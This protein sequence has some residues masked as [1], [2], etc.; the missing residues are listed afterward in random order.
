MKGPG[1][2]NADTDKGF[3]QKPES[4]TLPFLKMTEKFSRRVDVPAGEDVFKRTYFVA[5]DQ[6]RLNFHFGEDRITASSRLYTK[7]GLTHITEVDTLK[8]K[9]TGSALLEEYQRLLLAERECSQ[10]IRDVEREIRSILD[11]RMKEEQNIIL[12][13]PYYDV[14]R[15]KKEESDEEK[16]EEEQV[17]HDFLSA[18]LPSTINIRH[19]TRTECFAV[20]DKCLK[21]LKDRLIERANIIQARHDEETAALA[22]RQANFQRDRDQ[23]S[24]EEEEEYEKACEESMFRI[25]ILEQRL[26]KHEEQALQKYYQLDSKLRNDPRLAAMSMSTGD[27]KKGL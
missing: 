14:T 8:E 11:S 26:K 20:R 4:Q 25:H 17:E 6:I 2:F 27:Y 21:A 7:E 5:A 19:L 15:I 9:P 24:Q 3:E 16:Q 13:V 12:T 1:S 10:A 22:K 18:F 23:M